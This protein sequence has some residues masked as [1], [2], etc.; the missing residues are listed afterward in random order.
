MKKLCVVSLNELNANGLDH[1]IRISPNNIIN[2][3]DVDLNSS[4]G[5][6]SDL[7]SDTETVSSNSEICQKRKR[8]RLTHLTNEEKMMRRKLKNR[9][10]AQSARDRKKVKMD[11]LQVTCDQLKEQN[12][13]LK[14]ENAVLKENAQLL[15][16]EN[17]KLLKFKS[18]TDKSQ[19]PTPIILQP[20]LKQEH[21]NNNIVSLVSVTAPSKLHSSQTFLEADESA[22]FTTYAFQP[23]RQ[24]QGMFQRIIYMLILQTLGLIRGELLSS[25]GNITTTQTKQASQIKV[26]KLRLTLAKLY[27]MA[28]ARRMIRPKPEKSI[29]ILNTYKTFQAGTGFNKTGRLNAVNLALLVSMIVQAMDTSKNKR[30]Q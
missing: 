24:L 22:V 10:A 14:K 5:D 28:S 29:Q 3:I 13:R 17:R 9:V 4:I 27:R 6:D 16:N 26:A 1:K 18:D 2:R 11:D 25:T 30:K 19:S 12:E 20:V 15:I 23:K 21:H 7:A 8:Q